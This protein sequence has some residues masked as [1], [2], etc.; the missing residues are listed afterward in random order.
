MIS[1]V[2]LFDLLIWKSYQLQKRRA[3]AAQRLKSAAIDI[4]DLSINISRPSA[5]FELL[6]IVIADRN[7]NIEMKHI[8]ACPK[9]RVE[10]NRRVISDVR[11][12]EN[13]IGCSRYSD[14]L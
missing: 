4:L 5:A 1:T 6:G 9:L 11:L 2:L 8:F 3:L 10:C 7:S 14:L 13:N 12:Y